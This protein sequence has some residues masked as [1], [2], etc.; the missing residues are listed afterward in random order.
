MKDDDTVRAWKDLDRREDGWEGEHP[1]GEIA[2]DPVGGFSPQR[3]DL[4]CTLY[5]EFCPRYSYLIA[6]PT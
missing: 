6:C 4:Y 1:A 3:T 5:P 2:L